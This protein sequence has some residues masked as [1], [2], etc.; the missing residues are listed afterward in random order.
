[1]S[2]FV[3]SISAPFSEARYKLNAEYVSNEILAIKSSGLL[4]SWSSVDVFLP[5]EIP[6]E[7]YDKNLKTAIFLGENWYLPDSKRIFELLYDNGNEWHNSWNTLLKEVSN[8]LKRSYK[9]SVEQQI[10]FKRD[11]DNI[12]NEQSIVPHNIQ[13]CFHKPV[14]ELCNHLLPIYS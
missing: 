7:E 12:D 13:Q 11:E 4:S 6:P 14:S 1:M 3:E 9:K 5:F 8:T 2:T 10:P